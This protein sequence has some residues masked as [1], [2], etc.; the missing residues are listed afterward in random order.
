MLGWTVNLVVLDPL[1]AGRSTE[2]GPVEAVAG[3]VAVIVV[4]D[5]TVARVVAPGLPKVTAKAPLNPDPVI[6]TLVPIVPELGLNE[7]TTGLAASAG[8]V[9]AASAGPA[10]AVTA[11]AVRATAS[12]PAARARLL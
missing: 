7:L 9:P 8:A 3:T 1:V 4:S 2:T 11:P 5:L 12:I 6:V 10:P